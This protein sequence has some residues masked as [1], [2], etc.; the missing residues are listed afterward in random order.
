MGESHRRLTHESCKPSLII[1]SLGLAEDPPASEVIYLHKYF[2]IFNYFI[3][4]DSKNIGLSHRNTSPGCANWPIHLSWQFYPWAH[5]GFT[6]VIGPFT[7][8]LDRRPTQ[9][10]W[11]LSISSTMGPL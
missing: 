4:Q 1:M 11:Q 6:N 2:Q 10:V 9:D 8:C 7:L 5:V 3:S